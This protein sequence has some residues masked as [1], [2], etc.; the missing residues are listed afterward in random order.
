MGGGTGFFSEKYLNNGGDIICLD[1]SARNI[2]AGQLLHPEVPFIQGDLLSF[3]SD[4]LFDD[5]FAIMV[6][7]FDDLQSALEHIRSLMM[8]R[9]KFVTIIS[10]IERTLRGRPDYETKV[11]YGF[12]TDGEVAVKMHNPKKFGDIHAIIRSPARYIHTARMAG[13]LLSEFVP[14][15]A[16]PG[17]PHYGKI[18]YPDYPLFHLLEFR[19]SD[20]PDLTV[21]Y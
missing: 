21:P 20:Y 11:D 15:Y 14:I 16:Q 9:G 5:I 18:T 7:N 3:H 12:G 1:P 2:I 4:E 17:H 6:E 19:R 13:L 10:D 8:P